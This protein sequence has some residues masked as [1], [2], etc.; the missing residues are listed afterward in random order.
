MS[1]KD[2]YNIPLNV[3]KITYKWYLT[4]KGYNLLHSYLNVFTVA[5]ETTSGVFV[6]VHCSAT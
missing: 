3:L 4:N 1:F 2:L 5:L 6:K